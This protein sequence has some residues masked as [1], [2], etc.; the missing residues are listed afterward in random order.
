MTIQ[1]WPLV[2]TFPSTGVLIWLILALVIATVA[3]Y[4]PAHGA[5]HMAVRDVVAYE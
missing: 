2:Y 3:S 1:Q 4:L 5:V